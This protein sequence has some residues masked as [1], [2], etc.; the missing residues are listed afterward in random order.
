MSQ[1]YWHNTLPERRAPRFF[2]VGAFLMGSLWAWS[3]GI[4]HKAGQL[5]VL[6]V[7][8][9]LSAV[10]L[11]VVMAGSTLALSCAITVFVGWR[12]YIGLRAKTWL[13]KHLVGLGYKPSQ[14]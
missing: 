4:R 2:S 13:V 3:E 14:R 10:G 11:F 1:K 6:D 8:F 9:F 12:L 5:Y 7:V